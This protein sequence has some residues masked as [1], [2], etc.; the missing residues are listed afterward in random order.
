MFAGRAA[1]MA[2][3]GWSA[4]VTSSIRSGYPF[5]RRAAAGLIVVALRPARQPWT[6]NVDARLSRDLGRIPGCAECRLRAQA[7]GRN[8]LDR[9]NVLALRHS[10]GTVAPSLAEVQAVTA[11]GPF[12]QPIPASSADYLPAL[13]TNHD[14]VISV[15]EYASA[16]FA[17]ALD[18]LDPSILFGAPRQL[19][20]GL[21]VSF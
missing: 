13:D 8:L 20:L 5:D 16:R 17:A 4:S 12:V 6:A 9:E 10:T 19:R 11:G 7:D 3:S 1:G 18:R 2:A 15:T 21:E 14:N